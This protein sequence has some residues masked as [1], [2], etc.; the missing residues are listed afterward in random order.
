MWV[1]IGLD[2]LGAA[3]IGFG[4]YNNAKA[5]DYHDELIKL[6]NN[7]QLSD[8]DSKKLEFEDNNKKMQDA[9][10]LRNIFYATGGAL[11]AGGIVVHIWF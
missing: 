6:K 9:G 11:L 5:N 8:Y 7:V 4:L 3:A 10:K 2:V 1:A